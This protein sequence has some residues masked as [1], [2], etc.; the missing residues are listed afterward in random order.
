MKV[1]ISIDFFTDVPPPPFDLPI[2]VRELFLHH[3][4]IFGTPRRY[5]FEMLS[6]FAQDETQRNRL[7]Y[8]ASKEGQVHETS[9]FFFL[10]IKLSEYYLKKFFRKN[11]TITI[12]DRN[13]VVL[14]FSKILNPQSHLWNIFLISFLNFKLDPSQSHLLKRHFLSFVC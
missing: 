7:Q 8:F 12:K 1:M 6:H 4:D 11:C 14:I 10:L 9:K 5:F 3:L 2:S 13:E